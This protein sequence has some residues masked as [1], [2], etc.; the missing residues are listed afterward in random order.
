[1]GFFREGLGVLT[2]Y[3]S[4]SSSSQILELGAHAFAV[5]TDKSTPWTLK[6]GL[7]GEQHVF[8][9]AFAPFSP[10]GTALDVVDDQ[11]YAVKNESQLNSLVFAAFSQPTEGY[12]LHANSHETLKINLKGHGCVLLFAVRRY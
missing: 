5:A 3:L 12:V 10:T 11:G 9:V 7:G 6:T 2:Q 1:V 8:A 4:A